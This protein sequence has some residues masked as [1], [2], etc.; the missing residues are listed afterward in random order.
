MKKIFRK[1]KSGI[2]II[3]PKCY[4]E[5]EWCNRKFIMYEVHCI[6]AECRHIKV[7]AGVGNT[8]AVDKMKIVIIF[9]VLCNN[10][11]NEIFQLIGYF[12]DFLI[13]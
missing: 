1:I 4:V 5:I 2:G 11:K 3:D 12:F 7:R 10:N 9:G 8:I 6:I 13:M